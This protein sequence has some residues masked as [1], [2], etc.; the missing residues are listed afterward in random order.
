[1]TMLAAAIALAGC[2]SAEPSAAPEPAAT[3]VD[4]PCPADPA[5]IRNAAASLAPIQ[6]M[7]SGPPWKWS[8]PVVGAKPDVNDIC[9]TLSA[10][11]ITVEGASLSS[12]MQVLLFHRGQYIGTAQ[13]NS[14]I[15]INADPTR[16]TDDTVGL[17]YKIPG[18]CNA[19][20]DATYYCAQF[21]W[22]GS[23]VQTIGRPPDITG[24]KHELGSNPC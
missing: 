3:N 19:C 9:S 18:T 8:L 21:H 15:F 20:S 7:S 24:Y 2:H 14:N 17:R 1:M 5:V 12:P 4:K 22:D 11:L 23:K 16:S 10:A 6:V 13:P